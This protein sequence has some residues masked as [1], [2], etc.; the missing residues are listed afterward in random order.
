MTSEGVHSLVDTANQGLL[1]Y[2]LRRPR[3]RPT[4]ATLWAMAES[5][6][7]VLKLHCRAADFLH[8]RWRVLLRRHYTYAGVAPKSPVPW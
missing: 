5:S 1:L 7:S 8:R 6:T 4:S 2:G 3:A